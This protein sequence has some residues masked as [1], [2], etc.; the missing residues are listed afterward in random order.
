MFIAVS[1][2][3]ETEKP[4]AITSNEGRDM[5]TWDTLEEAREGIKAVPIYA[6]REIIILDLDMGE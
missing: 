2:H 4:V 3:P 5:M 6:F 1:I